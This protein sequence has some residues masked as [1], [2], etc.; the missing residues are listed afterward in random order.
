MT[1][2][3]AI[4][5]Y[6]RI[7]QS[8]LR[9]LYENGYRRKMQVVAINELTNLETLAYLTRYDTTHG[10]FPG[11]VAHEDDH[12]VIDDDRIAVLR[13]SDPR[14]I[15]WNKLGIDLVLDA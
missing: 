12:L 3:V 6:G 4:N 2:R 9:A 5:G 7:G 11:R 8:V 14:K 1:F 15:D 13:E 10:R